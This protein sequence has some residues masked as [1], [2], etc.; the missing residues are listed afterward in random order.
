[1]HDLYVLPKDINHIF[2]PNTLT[3]YTKWIMN[4]SKNF[5]QRVYF[6]KS[7]WQSIFSWDIFKKMPW[8]NVTQNK[9]SNQEIKITCESFVPGS[10]ANP[11]VEV[12][13]PGSLAFDSKFESVSSVFSLLVFHL[14]HLLFYCKQRQM[15][16]RGEW[17]KM[18]WF[19]VP[20]SLAFDQNLCQSHLLL[21]LN[22]DKCY[23]DEN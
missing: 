4:S 19:N 18:K 22:K 7:F 5:T 20:F 9:K 6:A 3:E 16:R 11:S 1:M 8:M 23:R 2:Q 17:K 13:V 12:A 21:C 15:F 10:L 14:S